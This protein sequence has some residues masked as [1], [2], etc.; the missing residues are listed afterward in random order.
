MDKTLRDRGMKELIR[1]VNACKVSKKICEK[2]FKNN[3]KIVDL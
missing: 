2:K 1:H 3:S